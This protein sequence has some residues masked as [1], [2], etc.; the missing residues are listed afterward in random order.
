MGQCASEPKAEQN[1][2]G[3]SE[4]NVKK[5]ENQLDSYPSDFESD[6]DED[7]A[8]SKAGSRRT[9]KQY[10]VEQ[11]IYVRD[12]VKKSGCETF[13]INFDDSAKRGGKKVLK[14]KRPA[15]CSSRLKV[16]PKGVIGDDLEV[17]NVSEK[18]L[19]RSA[20]AF[21]RPKKQQRKDSKA[22]TT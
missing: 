19:L 1:K 9:S 10:D 5:D 17:N 16:K 6:E 18:R 3:S 20:F 14:K 15:T 11:D 2:Q 21:G 8:G 12:I 22:G 13:V 7:M 4:I